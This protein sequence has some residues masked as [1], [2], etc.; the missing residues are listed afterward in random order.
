METKE[1]RG[2]IQTISKIKGIILKENN[3]K[4]YNPAN[5]EV[6]KTIDSKTMMGANIV[7]SLDEK[8]NYIKFA[9][10]SFEKKVPD[11]IEPNKNV[12]HTC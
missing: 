4:W 10:A 3:K 5:E 9:F 12:G 11:F 8:G 7:L 6:A 1:V 2:T